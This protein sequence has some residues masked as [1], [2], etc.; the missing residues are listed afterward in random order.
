MGQQ[1]ARYGINLYG[2]DPA[3]CCRMRK[4]EPLAASVAPYTG[5]ITGLRR[6]DSPLRATTG[7]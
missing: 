7:P 3:A 4:V 1:D 2:S 5:W 6:A